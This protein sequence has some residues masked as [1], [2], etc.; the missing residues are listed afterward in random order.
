MT[1][2][3]LKEQAREE[4]RKIGNSAVRVLATRNECYE[5]IDSL[6]D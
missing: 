1:T 4:F 5:F 3:E 2:E 6:I